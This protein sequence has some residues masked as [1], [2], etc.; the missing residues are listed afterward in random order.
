MCPSWV[1]HVVASYR[2]TFMLP[3]FAVEDMGSMIHVQ[4]ELLTER[5]GFNHFCRTLRLAVGSQLR[6]QKSPRLLSN[7]LF[8]SPEARHHL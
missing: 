7:L 8:V 5:L 1:K 3:S 4:R 6:P 2:D